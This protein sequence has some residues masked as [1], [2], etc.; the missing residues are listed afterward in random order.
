LTSE[1]V[2][3][4]A[5]GRLVESVASFAKILEYVLDDAIQLQLLLLSDALDES[6][7][8]CELNSLK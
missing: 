3:K 6:A 5:A 7:S 2:F 4:M 1:F 8:N